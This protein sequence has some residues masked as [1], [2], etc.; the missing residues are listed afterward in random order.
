MIP[1]V[2]LD[3][4]VIGPDG[5]IRLPHALRQAAG[6]KPGDQLRVIWIPPD[7]LLMRKMGLLTDE[8]FEREM[9]TFHAALQAEGY[10]T[11]ERIVA[12]VED[13][14]REQMQ[15]IFAQ[16]GLLWPE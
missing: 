6:L 16:R 8:E 5:V 2:E 9:T 10:D 15:E 13:V 14:K 7:E 1:K 3:R 11:H 12:L 4:T